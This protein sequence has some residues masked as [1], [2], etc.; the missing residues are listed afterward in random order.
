MSLKNYEKKENKQTIII[1][2]TVMGPLSGQS[3][4]ITAI[5]RTLIN[6]CMT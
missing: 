4:I 5:K 3:F 6:K 2:N 1:I